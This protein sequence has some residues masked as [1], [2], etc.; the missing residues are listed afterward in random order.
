MAIGVVTTVAERRGARELEDLF[1]EHYE[2]VY[3]TAYS[4]VNNT[5]DAEDILQTVFLRLVRRELSPDFRTN[6]KGYFYRAAVNA[7]LDVIRSR[8]R[9]E[10]VGDTEE[11][12]VAVEAPDSRHADRMHRLLVDALTELTPE[13]V[14]ILI[15]RYVH[16]YSDA[17]IA[18]LLGT[19]RTVIA[20]RLFRSRARLRKLMR[21]SRGE[22]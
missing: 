7:S 20:V 14:H 1:Q 12:D 18:R 11:F 5:A 17:H 19:S 21:D 8:R 13:A 9:Y 10:L 15:L 2:L 4:I 16:D 6:V 22:E 3:R